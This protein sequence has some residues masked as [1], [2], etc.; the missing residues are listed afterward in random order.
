MTGQ[1]LSH[2]QKLFVVESQKAGE[3]E[4]LSDEER[5]GRPPTIVLDEILGY[6]PAASPGISPQ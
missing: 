1:G 2:Q 5:R 6:R 3:R 4:D